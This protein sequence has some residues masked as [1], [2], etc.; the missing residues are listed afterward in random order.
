MSH[1]TSSLPEE[2]VGNK[3]ENGGQQGPCAEISLRALQETGSWGVLSEKIC[4][5]ARIKEQLMNHRAKSL[6]LPALAS[7]STVSLFLLVL[8]RVRMEPRFLPELGT[9]MVV[10]CRVASRSN[11]VWGAGSIPGPPRRRNP[12]HAGYCRHLSRHRDVWIVGVL[13]SRQ[14]GDGAQRLCF[15]PSLVLHVGSFC[16]GG[17]ARNCFALGNCAVSYGTEIE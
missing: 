10:L 11:F 2:S 13:D 16:M 9:G 3:T 15:T 1:F 5:A 12:L 8:T 17:A 7:F 4:R 14:C 6:W